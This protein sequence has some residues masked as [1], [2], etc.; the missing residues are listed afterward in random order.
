MTLIE[1]SECIPE[2]EIIVSASESPDASDDDVDQYCLPPDS[3]A[4][5]ACE[6]ESS[7]NVRH[8]YWKRNGKSI[9]FDNENKIEHVVNEL[10]H[11]LIIRNV[12]PS[13]S[14][15]YSVCINQTEFRVTR[16]KVNA[17]VRSVS[18]SRLKRI[19]S[20]SLE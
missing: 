18:Q 1:L 19:P 4:T 10:K 7:E 12:Q 16:L 9:V 17:L 5:I 6:L 15:L 20:A 8:L 14:G 3:T 2:K 13:D 11:Y